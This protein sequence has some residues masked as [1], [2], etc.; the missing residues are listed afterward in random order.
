VSVLKGRRFGHESHG[1]PNLAHVANPVGMVP[2]LTGGF[3]RIP[4]SSRY[5]CSLG[6]TETHGRLVG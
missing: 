6:S 2:Q 1:C 4:A 3:F 5:N